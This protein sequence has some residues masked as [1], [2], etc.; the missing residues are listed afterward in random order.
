MTEGLRKK[1]LTTT[2]D[3]EIMGGFEFRTEDI[4]QQEYPQLNN[5]FLH[6]SYCSVLTGS[7]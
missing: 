4:S 3:S 7:H 6:L 1:I 2:T 5:S